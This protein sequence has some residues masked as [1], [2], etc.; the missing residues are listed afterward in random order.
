MEP[1]IMLR[2]AQ[3][4]QGNAR[5]YE[6]DARTLAKQRSYG[7]AT[8]L[9]I[10]GQEECG[11][12][13]ALWHLAAGTMRKSDKD[14]DTLFSNHKTKQMFG[15]LPLSAA[16][17]FLAALP[18]KELTAVIKSYAKSIGD[19]P[20]EADLVRCFASFRR[21]LEKLC[22]KHAARLEETG[23]R[24]R[25][26]VVHRDQEVRVKGH[27]QH[28]KHRGLYVGHERRTK[29]IQ[30]PSQVTKADYRAQIDCLRENLML[31]GDLLSKI[32][33]EQDLIYFRKMMIPMLMDGVARKPHS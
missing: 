1:V 26:A 7:H 2:L 20:S 5:S 31:I 29:A 10:L 24:L 25:D 16:A 3:A 27:I 15:A 33:S 14:I 30:E 17:V 21:D 13:T 22:A 6:R 28:L 9:A 18:R 8:A 12:A 23:R 32:K 11:K 19:S 4:A